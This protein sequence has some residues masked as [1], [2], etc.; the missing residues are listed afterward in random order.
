MQVINEK[1]L[2]EN[3]SK[4]TCKK[5]D[6]NCNNFEKTYYEL[7]NSKQKLENLEF[8]KNL[9]ISIENQEIKNENF[10]HEFEFNKKNNLNYNNL[11]QVEQFL[12]KDILLSSK[13]LDLND[14]SNLKQN[15]PFRN[16]SNASKISEINKDLNNSVN[17]LK[18]IEENNLEVLSP[19]NIHHIYDSKSNN[20]FN[21]NWNNPL[22]KD[23]SINAPKIHFCNI[24]I[25]NK[26]LKNNSENNSNYNK[27]DNLK[28][29]PENS[30]SKNFF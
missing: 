14:L 15:Y 8:F 12:Y 11:P 5:I 13:N 21:D 25:I 22:L 28:Q 4:E 10:N 20:F 26:Y 1:N 23:Y 30:I 17:S 2:L 27:E 6:F 9:N 7:L 16:K 18:L 19:N 24:D 29:Y 3:K